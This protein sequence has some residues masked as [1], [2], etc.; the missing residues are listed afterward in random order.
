[1]DYVSRVELVVRNYSEFRF[2]VEDMLNMLEFESRLR[3]GKRYIKL[4]CRCKVVFIGDVHGDY[5]TLL[6]IFEKI[7]ALDIL[8][9]GGRIVFLG[10]YVD[11]GDEQIRTVA[12]IAMLKRD[13]GDRVVLLRGNHEPPPNLMPSPHDFPYRLVE[14][15]GFANGEEL[16]SVF[17]KV[18]AS[19]PLVLYM[20]KRLVA[21]HGG[22][23]VTRLL[24][25]NNVDS[26]LD[27]EEKDFE[28]VLWSDPSDDVEEYEFNFV[29]GAGLIWGEKVTDMLL[30]KLGVFLVV[31][32]HEPC[33]GYMF[34]HRKK[35]LTLFSMKGYY[36]N[37]YA[38]A[39]VVDSE[40]LLDLDSTQ[41]LSYV[42]KS[43]V[44]V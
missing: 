41:I 14:A 8:K 36:G 17:Q 34:K 15:Y 31:R 40:K 20:P 16:Y 38:G 12:F 35:V 42:E 28:E 29:R 7:G 30:K 26:I 21:F 27:V 43:I 37:S 22:P 2:L 24:A 5:Y 1:M 19:M 18:F 25:Y 3:N 33:N 9:N 44:V 6:N 4:D 10:D 32:G 13:W 11:R 23:P 39:L